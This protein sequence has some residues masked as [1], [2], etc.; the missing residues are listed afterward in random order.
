MLS[1]SLDKNGNNEW[2][3]LRTE[4]ADSTPAYLYEQ[5]VSIYEATAEHF[6][7]PQPVKAKTEGEKE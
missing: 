1:S 5:A 2:R 6:A 4:Y 7:T 3:N